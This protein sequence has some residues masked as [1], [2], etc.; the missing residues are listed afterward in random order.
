MPK[1]ERNRNEYVCAFRG[2]RDNYQVPL[3][4]AESGRLDT[5]ITDLYATSTIQRLAQYL[6]SP[7]DEKLEGR[8]DPRLLSDQVEC[9]WGTT[10]LEWIRHA[11]RMSAAQTYA[12][13]DAKYAEA[14]AD[15]ARDSQS[16]LLLYTPYAWEAFRASYPHSPRRVLFQYHPHAAFERR[17]LREDA[18]RFPD[19][20]FDRA[21]RADTGSSLTADQ[22]QRTEDAWKHADFI[23]CASS[24]TQATLEEAG[25]DP[26]SCIVIPYG[27]SLPE[28]PEET[29][30]PESS[31]HVLFVGSGTQR[32]GLHHLLRA[33]SN[34]TLPSSSHLT[35]VCRVIDPALKRLAFATPRTTLRRGVSFETLL[36]LYRKSSLFAMPSLIEGFGQVYLE[37][38]SQGCP[39]LGTPHT[40]LPDVGTEE[41]GIFTVEPGNT[42]ALVTC[43]E[44]LA[45]VLPENLSLRRR[46]RSRA[47][48]FSWSR[49]RSQISHVL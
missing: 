6:P 33:W 4:L 47:R 44:E 25:A 14:A 36:S 7:W 15:R 12:N 27:V 10:A 43:I 2:R 20:D 23:L 49:F 28:D 8:H 1:P 22:Q 16:H 46:A 18:L 37:A 31:F 35:L 38:L 40:C 3:A 24:F 45:S 9:L 11:L 29:V 34:A 26:S 42:G 30:D 13:L 32:K 21:G 5:F 41:E 39:V 17:I 48:R 19:L